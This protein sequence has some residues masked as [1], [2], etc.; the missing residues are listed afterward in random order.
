MEVNKKSR[1]TV[2]ISFCD[3]TV[4]CRYLLEFLRCSAVTVMELGVNIASLLLRHQYD[5]SSQGIFTTVQS[6]A[7]KPPA[8]PNRS[9]LVPWTVHLEI[10]A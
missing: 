7:K 1:L 4:A 6:F 2:K 8:G 10:R 5:I 3:V 9:M